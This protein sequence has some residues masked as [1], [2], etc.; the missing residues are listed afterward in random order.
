[1]TSEKEFA[2]ECMDDMLELLQAELKEKEYAVEMSKGIL[3]SAS[4][5]VMVQ[6]IAIN[7]EVVDGYIREGGTKTG[8]AQ[9]VIRFSKKDATDIARKVSNKNNVIGEAIYW[10]D[11]VRKEIVR[12]T[13]SII[14]LKKQR[15]KTIG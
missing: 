14:D 2:I 9:S 12:I 6:G 8:P 1:M 4:F 15:T 7:P 10:V 11:A 13:Q 5:I 3:T